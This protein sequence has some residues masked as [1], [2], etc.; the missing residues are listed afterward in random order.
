M[1]RV[2]K[3]L[4]ASVALN[5]FLV[6]FFVGG[7]LHHFAMHTPPAPPP[8]KK[9][10]SPERLA[11]FH[12]AQQH[13]RAAQIATRKKI[14]ALYDTMLTILRAPQFDAKAYQATARQIRAIRMDAMDS[15][16]D[17]MLPVMESMTQPERAALADHMASVR[18]MAQSRRHKP[19]P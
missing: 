9:T 5:V 11:A 17:S 13:S 1:D 6:G 12:N 16:F 18:H 2:T 8:L 7:H 3:G 10:I 19:K 15:A 4:I 14:K